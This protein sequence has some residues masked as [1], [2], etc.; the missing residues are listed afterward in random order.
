MI[1]VACAGTTFSFEIKLIFVQIFALKNSYLY[2]AVENG[3]GAGSS[4]HCI[5]QRFLL[6]H[7]RHQSSEQPNICVQKAVKE[8]NLFKKK[9]FNCLNY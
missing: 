8:T 4:D 7:P 1:A 2:S 9:Y 6:H 5:A 3:D